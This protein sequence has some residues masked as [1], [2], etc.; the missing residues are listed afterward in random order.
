MSILTK[1]WKQNSA[2]S[3]PSIQKRQMIEI[4]NIFH[5]ESAPFCLE[6]QIDPHFAPEFTHVTDSCVETVFALKLHQ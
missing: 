4:R 5:S 6:F 3:M 1:L 2:D